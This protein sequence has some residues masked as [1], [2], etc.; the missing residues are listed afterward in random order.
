MVEHQSSL[1]PTSNSAGSIDLLLET[2]L[3]IDEE[4]LTQ[5]D[6]HL[7][8]HKKTQSYR[9]RQH[10]QL[11]ITA[12]STS[13]S[14][15]SSGATQSKA[16]ESMRNSHKC[17]LHHWH[18][19]H[20]DSRT[21]DSI[22]TTTSSS[23]SDSKAHT[24][25]EEEDDDSDSDDH[26]T[27][28][29]HEADRI[30]NEIFHHVDSEPN[31]M[32]YFCTEEDTECNKEN[33]EQVVEDEYGFYDD[34]DEAPALSQMT[35]FDTLNTTAW[36]H[37]SGSAATS[38]NTLNFM[39]P[40]SMS[41]SGGLWSMMTTPKKVS[42]RNSAN[43]L[44][45][46]CASEGVVTTAR[47]SCSDFSTM[48]PTEAQLYSNMIA[49]ERNNC[50]CCTQISYV[51]EDHKTSLT[52]RCFPSEQSSQSH[53]STVPS[54]SSSSAGHVDVCL[55]I[56]GIRIVHDVQYPSMDIAEY[57]I[58]LHINGEV[59][60]TWKRYE[61]FQLVAEACHEYMQQQVKYLQ[62][63]KQQRRRQ[64]FYALDNVKHALPVIHELYET[65]DAWKDVVKHRPYWFKPTNYVQFIQEESELLQEFMKNLLFEIP[66]VRM[67]LEFIL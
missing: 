22:M 47:S 53:T 64:Q 40:S 38:S 9:R 12:N 60:S 20:Y 55:A 27:A 65:L 37:R 15:G 13:S 17:H 10:K 34:C 41:S 16:V 46:M 35:S 18:R 50:H 44:A 48:K 7:S 49:A 56:A 6:Q 33:V 67:L 30:M 43:E 63:M 59:Y 21:F 8:A 11:K 57:K 3:S 54:S 4:M 24:D 36:L 14:G 66:N 5:L 52:C 29:D 51:F 62:Q 45:S 28:A 61:D 42:T 32:L 25:I 1:L 23:R 39:S 31:L 58:Q 2:T 19:E 26:D